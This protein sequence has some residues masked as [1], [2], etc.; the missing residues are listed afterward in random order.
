MLRPE[1]GSQGRTG[2]CHSLLSVH[3]ASVTADSRTNSDII[4]AFCLSSKKWQFSL[5]F[6]H[7]VKIGTNVGLSEKWNGIKWT[8]KIL[9]G[10]LYFPQGKLTWCF[11]CST[12][13]W[14][15]AC[16]C[17]HGHLTYMLNCMLVFLAHHVR[18][19]MAIPCPEHRCPSGMTWM[20][21][22]HRGQNSDLALGKARFFT[23]QEW[24]L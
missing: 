8:F 22:Q 20:T 23:P 11:Y 4:F 7:L 19:G 9:G 17:L 21:C 3:T 24:W 16:N 18:L 15:I 5:D 2:W 6:F 1:C 13:E 10:Y 12:S 14:P